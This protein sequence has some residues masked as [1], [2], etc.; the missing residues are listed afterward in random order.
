MIHSKAGQASPTGMFWSDPV[1]RG[2]GLGLPDWTTWIRFPSGQ[3]GPS[4]N[5]ERTVNPS[6]PE[7][8]GA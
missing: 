2:G 1:R 7:W 3:E 6:R 8:T 5:R 4:T